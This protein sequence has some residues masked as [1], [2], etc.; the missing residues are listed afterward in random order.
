MPKPKVLRKCSVC[1]FESGSRGMRSH[2]M[3]RC[4]IEQGYQAF[5]AGLPCEAPAD[6]THES[7]R[8]AWEQGWRAAKHESK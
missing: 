6:V 8:G 1:G 3:A 7:A 4:L 5:R 2:T